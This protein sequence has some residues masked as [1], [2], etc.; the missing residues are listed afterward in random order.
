MMEKKMETTIMGCIGFRDD[1][2]VTCRRH[3]G[4]RNAVAGPSLTFMGATGNVLDI[5]QYV[6]WS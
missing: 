6:V 3:P 5:S 1:A 2:I 4:I